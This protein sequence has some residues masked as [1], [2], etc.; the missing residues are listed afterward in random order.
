MS[1]PL[2]EQ[3]LALCLRQTVPAT[4]KKAGQ[5]WYK[6]GV[7]LSDFSVWHPLNFSH[8][9]SFSRRRD[10]PWHSIRFLHSLSPHC[11]YVYHHH[12]S[13]LFFHRRLRPARPTSPPHQHTLQPDRP[14]VPLSHPSHSPRQTTRLPRRSPHRHLQSPR[15]SRKVRLCDPTSRPRH[16]RRHAELGG[17]TG[18]GVCH[19]RAWDRG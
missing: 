5:Q 1:I 15:L 17:P 11:L 13:L 18:Q 7:C 12:G 2:L 10:L 8:N 3:R 19:H 16:V 6:Y 9:S 4:E 14:P